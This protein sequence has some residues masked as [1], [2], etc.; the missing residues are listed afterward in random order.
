MLKKSAKLADCIKPASRYTVA[1]LQ[2]E[3]VAKFV[4]LT[5]A[6]DAP[7]IE[8]IRW[9]ATAAIYDAGA[10]C[11]SLMIKH[12]AMIT[13]LQEH[14]DFRMALVNILLQRDQTQKPTLQLLKHKS[15][16]S[17][18]AKKVY[19]GIELIQNLIEPRE[20]PPGY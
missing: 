11:R 20:K 1:E 4:S 3:K 14:E 12:S 17:S 5:Y 8:E 18:V 16:Y 19:I 2:G 9:L 10:T 15:I 7:G 13:V 6:C